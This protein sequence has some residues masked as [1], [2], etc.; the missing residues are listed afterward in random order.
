MSITATRILRVLSSSGDM[1]L[2]DLSRL[3]PRKFNDHRDFYPLASLLHQGFIEDPYASISDASNTM[4]ILGSKAQ[5]LSWKLYAMSTAEKTATYK[6]QTWSIHG[7]D[8][9]LRDQRF[10]LTGAGYLYL[11]ESKIRRNDRIFAGLLAI[12]SAAIAAYFTFL[13]GGTGT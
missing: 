12:I 4:Q 6:G 3:L 13:F 10:S 7:G 1:T 9:L 8:E 2:E 5:L 11:E